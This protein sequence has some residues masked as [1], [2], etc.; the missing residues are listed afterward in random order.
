[1]KTAIK[2]SELV[3]FETCSH[4]PIY[5]SVVEFNE[6]TLSFLSRHTG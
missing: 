5:E 2:G 1:M 4:A 3:I 6:K